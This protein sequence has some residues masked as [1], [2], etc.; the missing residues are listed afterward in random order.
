MARLSEAP[1]EDDE[2]ETL[3]DFLGEH[4]SVLYSS[5]QVAGG[6]GLSKRTG[7]A[8]AIGMVEKHRKE[9]S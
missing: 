1:A 9:Q 5:K 4:V 7:K 6:A 8:F 2:R 3:A